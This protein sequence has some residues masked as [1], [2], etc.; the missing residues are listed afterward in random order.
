M[1]AAA[2][3]LALSSLEVDLGGLEEGQTIT[4]KWRG[5]PVFISYR[6]EADIAKAAAVPM[7]DLVDPQPDSDRV[8]DPK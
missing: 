3:T 7:S 4:V 8:V 6:S 5:K 1:Q 2:D